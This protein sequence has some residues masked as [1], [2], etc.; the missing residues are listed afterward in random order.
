MQ[1]ITDRKNNPGLEE[2]RLEGLQMSSMDRYDVMKKVIASIKSMKL[3]KVKKSSFARPCLES[4][5]G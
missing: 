2:S 3:K 1:T 5:K 4:Q